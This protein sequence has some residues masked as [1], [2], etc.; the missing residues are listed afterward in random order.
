M[1]LFRTTLSGVRMKVLPGSNALS[2]FRLDQLLKKLRE[3][4]VNIV[5]ITVCYRY[6]LDLNKAMPS[7]EETH[8]RDILIELGQAPVDIA[9]GELLVVAPRPGTI[10]PWS[11]KATDILQVSG[12]ASVRRIERATAYSVQLSKALTKEQHQRVESL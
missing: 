6:I 9:D 1:P 4:T 2:D 11:S 5:E 7:E 10:S 8:L 12:L 3:V